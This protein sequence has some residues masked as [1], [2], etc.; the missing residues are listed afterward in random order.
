MEKMIKKVAK[1]IRDLKTLNLLKGLQSWY[2][3]NKKTEKLEL[4][5]RPV[6]E[7]RAL[8]ELYLQMFRRLSKKENYEMTTEGIF[9]TYDHDAYYAEIIFS[10]K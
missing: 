9:E 8:L 5:I 1:I 7:E 10:K 4:A 3:V 2:Y 6:V